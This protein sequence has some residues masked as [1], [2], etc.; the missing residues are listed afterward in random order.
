MKRFYKTYI[1]FL[2]FL[3]TLCTISC[4]K[5][6]YRERYELNE[7]SDIYATYEGKGRTRLFE[8]R[9]VDDKIYLDID[10]Y[11]PIDSD[12][13]VDLSKILIRATVP[14]DALVSPSLSDFWDLTSPKEL[15]VT[16]GSGEKKTYTVIANK[17]GSTDVSNAILRYNDEGGDPQE[18]QAIIIGNRINFSLVPGTVLNNAKLSYVINRHASGS[19]PNET[20]INLATPQPFVVTAPG[21]A[22]RDYT[23][24]VIEAVKL[25]KGIRPGSAKIMFA[26]RLK[27]D[28]GIAVDD[29][30]GGI[31]ATGPYVVLN[32][33]DQNSIY[34]DAFTGAK[35]GEI[36]L[37]SIRGGLRN[38]YTTADDA[39]NIF[40]CNL[41]PNDGDTF[42]IWKISSVTGTPQPFIQWSSGSTSFG[43]KFSIIGDV[44]RNAIVTVPVVGV[45]S[46]SFA[47][48]QVVNGNLV[49]QTPEMVTISGYSW[50]N[51]N[52]DVIYT[53]PTDASSDYY[54]IGYSN[55]RLARVNG[56]TNTIMAQLDQLEANFIANSVDYIEFNNA[57]F[58]AY[59]HVNSFNWG[60]ADQVFLIDT[61]GGF[62]GNPSANTTPGLIWAPDKGKYG[63]NTL[64]AKAN[65]NGTG[66]VAMTLSENGYYLYLYFMFTNGY[67]VGVQFDCVDVE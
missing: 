21:N 32:T 1:A 28:L 59:N 25:A 53:S 39:G 35:V 6:E 55:N 14:S 17:Q 50:S 47:R 60:S 42:N 46:S 63:A 62:S 26:K 52:I 7:I 3:G 13:E 15:T 2:V 61:E 8:A 36:D 23:I 67:V 56:S 51:N 57:K 5:V 40:V 10:Y 44:N 34:I 24:Q 45:L 65:G 27:N 64:G 49:S 37:G 20:D 31:A 18:V 4:Q 11:H 48:W 19:L 29:V 43:R 30:T 9:I 16:S 41:V 58:V 54:A 33:R 12:N 22:Q 38:F 66:D